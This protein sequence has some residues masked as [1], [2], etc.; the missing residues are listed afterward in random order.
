M[1]FQPPGAGRERLAIKRVYCSRRSSKEKINTFSSKKACYGMG[2]GGLKRSEAGNERSYWYV[3]DMR[4]VQA[5][6]GEGEG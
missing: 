6:W 1:S 4:A 3:C 5:V 2:D